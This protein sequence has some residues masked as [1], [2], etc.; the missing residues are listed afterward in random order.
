MRLA[1]LA[2]CATMMFGC[3]R[4]DSNNSPTPGADLGQLV[5]VQQPIGTAVVNSYQPFREGIELSSSESGLDHGITSTNFNFSELR[6]LWVR[7]KVNGINDTSVVHFT[8]VTPNG[9]TFYEA[10]IAYSPDPAT[11]SVY[12]PKA[13]HEITVYQAKA[14]GTGHAIDYVVPIVGTASS[15]YPVAGTWHLQVEI[16]GHRT[17]STD[18]QVSYT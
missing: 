6:E 1:V 8:L 12:V 3:L 4:G 17:F 5:Q 13:P 16:Q 11:K 7:V 10:Y 15:R 14:M 2:T 18:I 9:S